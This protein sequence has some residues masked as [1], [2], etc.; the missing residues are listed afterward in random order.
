M[1]FVSK[2]QQ[3]KCYAIKAANPNSKWDC[4]EFSAKTNFTK[5]PEKKQNEKTKKK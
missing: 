5:L 3:K 4:A 2:K 1:P